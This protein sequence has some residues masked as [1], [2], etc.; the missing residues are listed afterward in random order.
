MDKI[1]E[2]PKEK[3]EPSKKSILVLFAFL[4]ITLILSLVI[5]DLRLKRIVAPPEAF[6]GQ[7]AD[8]T[9]FSYENSRSIFVRVC[10]ANS[11]SNRRLRR[12]E[13]KRKCE[14]PDPACGVTPI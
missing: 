4:G 12:M 13:R 14:K 1:T 8:L 9:E 6:D 7:Q 2:I 3:L 5:K 10:N 11:G